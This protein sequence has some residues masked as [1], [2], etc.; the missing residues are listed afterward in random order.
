[1]NSLQFVKGQGGLGRPLSNND[2]VSSLLFY[3]ASLPSGFGA[4]DRIKVVYSLQQAEALGITNTGIGATQSTATYL[5]TNAGADGNRIVITVSAVEGTLTLCDYFQNATDAGGVNACASKIAAQINLGTS[6][7]GFTASPATA[8]VTITASAKQ[9]IYLNS[10]TPYVVTITGTVAGTLTQNVVPGV[11]SDINIMHYHISEFF[12]MQPKGKLY[13]SIQATAD[14]PAFTKVTET[15]NFAQGEIRQMGVYQRTS[16]FATAQVT[17]LQTQATTLANNKKPLSIIY[18]ADFETVTDL[19]TLSNLRALSAPN[20]SVTIG[21]DNG[22]IGL[23]LWR[24]TDKSIGILG[25]TLG[26]VAF[27]KVSDAINWYSKFNLSNGVELDSIGFANGDAYLSLSDS[28]LSAIDGLGYIFAV[29]EVDLLGTFFNNSSTAVS[30]ASDY[31]YIE[32][33]RTIDKAIRNLRTFITPALGSP[34][35]VNATN[36]TLSEDTIAYFET[37]G[38]RALEA[39]LNNG[40]IQGYQVIIDPSQNVLSTSQLTMAVEIVPTGVARSIVVNI[41]YVVQLTQ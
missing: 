22:G 23:Q 11:A 2:H 12:R 6:I 27:A 31:A 1:M 7:H 24:A 30:I 32:S 15:Q 35:N 8:T 33:N 41:G 14:V 36:G 28:L 18:Q 3:S 5:V 26:A 29:K 16:A 21:Q 13:V 9:G 19:S 37:L 34:I 17:A 39:M 40:E 25:A 4:S 20:V 38:Q 10:G